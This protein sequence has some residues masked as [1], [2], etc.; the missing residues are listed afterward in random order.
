MKV[1]LRMT[2]AHVD[3]NM[4]LM[5]EENQHTI[6]VGLAIDND[7][8]TVKWNQLSVDGLLSRRN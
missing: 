7:G 4:V 1:I 8:L 2:F 3:S 6:K 5:T